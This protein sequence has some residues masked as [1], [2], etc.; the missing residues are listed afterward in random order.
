MIDE[1][2][3]PEKALINKANLEQN[4]IHRGCQL[5]QE[6]K[7]FGLVLTSTRSC[8]FVP[9]PSDQNPNFEAILT[10]ISLDFGQAVVI[11]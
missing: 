2:L 8:G 3:E 1:N 10:L 5:W 11:S 6:V 4:R 9:R 7:S